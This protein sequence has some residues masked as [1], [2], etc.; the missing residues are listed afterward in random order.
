MIEFADHQGFRDLRFYACKEHSEQVGWGDL[1]GQ[2]VRLVAGLWA[3]GGQ[4]PDKT[5]RRGII[6]TR[7]CPGQER[8]LSE[9]GRA[10]PR[11]LTTNSIISSGM[12]S[13]KSNSPQRVCIGFFLCLSR[14]S[15]DYYALLH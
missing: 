12:G 5:R 10:K 2:N 11:C 1:L 9:R 7:S 8:V 3:T 13:V 6:K 4:P 14:V 15:F